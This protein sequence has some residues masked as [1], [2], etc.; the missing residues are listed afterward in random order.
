[1][2]FELTPNFFIYLAG[3]SLSLGFS[4]IPKLESWF[5]AQEAKTK[6]LVMLGALFAISVGIVGLSCSDLY[7]LIECTQ[8]GITAV[9]ETFVGAAIANQTTY[10]FT[11]HIP[12]WKR[13]ADTEPT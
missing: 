13:N 10:T 12:L 9:V 2:S 11:K 8:A 1:M 4:Y 3:I 7:P 5:E 6:A